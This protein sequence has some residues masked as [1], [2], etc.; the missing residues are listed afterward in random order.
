[1]RIEL[2]SIQALK[3]IFY[4][5]FVIAKRKVFFL[6]F[7]FLVF[8]MYNDIAIYISASVKS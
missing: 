4:E 1:M 5:S 6:L 3:L 7:V 8:L 2:T